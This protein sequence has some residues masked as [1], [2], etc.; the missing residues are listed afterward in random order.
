MT[1]E[2]ARL[3][4][5]TERF[6]VRLADLVARRMK[7][8]S[9]LWNLLVITPLVFLA[10]GRRL[11]TRGLD[12]LRGMG[13]RTPLILVANHRSRYDF[14]AVTALVRWHAGLLR[15]FFFPVRSAYFY[16]HLSGILLNLVSAGMGMFPP[17]FR[18]AARRRVN[19]W[20]VS[21]CCD[22]LRRARRVIGIHPEGTRNRTDDPYQIIDPKPGVGKIALEAPGARVLP[23]FV[24]GIGDNPLTEYLYNFRPSRHPVRVLFGSEVV[25]E[26]LRAEGSRPLTQKQAM[27]RCVAAVRALALEARAMDSASGVSIALAP[28]GPPAPLLTERR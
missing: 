10:I 24:V 20:S 3:L 21:R 15:H 13:A 28:A 16:D 6:G 7:L 17:I 11:D 19:D 1:A 22:E 8:A 26:D 18:D 14:F 2:Q 27:E 12:H 4:T 23:V 9:T 5:R 25:V